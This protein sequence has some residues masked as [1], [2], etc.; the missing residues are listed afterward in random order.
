[1]PCCVDLKLQENTILRCLQ[2]LGFLAMN[3]RSVRVL[4][5]LRLFVTNKKKRRNVANMFSWR[6]VASCCVDLKLQENTILR[7]LQALGFLAMNGR[8]V[9]VLSTLRLFVTNKKKRR[10]VANMFSWRDVASC[11][12]KKERY[13]VF[14]NFQ[15]Y[16]VFCNVKNNV[17]LPRDNYFYSSCSTEA[18]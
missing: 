8:S 16:Y 14:W 6:D 11:R 3:G 2:A 9:R 13:I 7:C 10:N 17:T 4:S 1:M 15:G 12:M 18:A 5:T